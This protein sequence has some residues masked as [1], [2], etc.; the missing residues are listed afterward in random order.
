VTD[1]MALEEEFAKAPLTRA[2]WG[3]LLRYLAPHKKPLLLAL[4]IE[5]LWVCSMLTDPWLI[6]KAVDGPLARADVPGV[7]FYVFWLTFSV[8]ARVA[9]TVFE[10]RIST[11]VG[12]EVIHRMRRDVFDHLQRLSMRYYDRTKQG[13][14]L[15]RADRDVDSLEHLT[16][17]PVIP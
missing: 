7:A 17:G 9:V 15:A 11:R 6:K 8:V 10:L 14:I 5:A 4:S 13:R 3:R 2:T 1:E 12:I 16:W